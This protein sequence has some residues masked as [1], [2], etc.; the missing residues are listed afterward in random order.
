MMCF[1]G[2]PTSYV[3]LGSRINSRPS[4]PSCASE[5]CCSVLE[6][7]E[8]VKSIPKDGQSAVCLPLKYNGKHCPVLNDERVT[9]FCVPLRDLCVCMMSYY[10]V[11]NVR[12][13]LGRVIAVKE[14][15]HAHES[16]TIAIACTRRSESMP[17]HF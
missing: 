3:V 9:I 12:K 7:R 17:L 11:S 6:Q 10:S 15:R 13:L 2:V 14:D 1:V 16:N 4:C 5:K 8:M